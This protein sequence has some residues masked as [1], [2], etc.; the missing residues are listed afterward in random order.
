[1]DRFPFLGQWNRHDTFVNFSYFI[2]INAIWVDFSYLDVNSSINAAQGQIQSSGRVCTVLRPFLCVCVC[3]RVCVC[4]CACVCV[5]ACVCV[6]VCFILTASPDCVNPQNISGPFSGSGCYG[7]VWRK[8]TIISTNQKLCPQNVSFPPCD[9]RRPVPSQGN[10]LTQE[11]KS[12]CHLQYHKGGE[13]GECIIWD[14]CDPV[15]SQRHG[16]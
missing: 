10:K 8:A 12:R 2:Y 15:E 7:D 3:V 5:S 4:V 13:V 11:S 16:L 1:M 6:C 9:H 14:V